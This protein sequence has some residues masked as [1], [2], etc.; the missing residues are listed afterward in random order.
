M[1]RSHKF[2]IE[3]SSYSH[4]LLLSFLQESKLYLLLKII[5]EHINLIGKD[6]MHVCVSVSEPSLLQ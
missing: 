5:N 6:V 3:L 4:Q 2:D 1:F